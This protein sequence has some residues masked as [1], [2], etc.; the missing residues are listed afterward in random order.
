MFKNKI[1]SIQ[2]FKNEAKV[3][4]EPDSSP[5][6]WGHYKKFYSK[7]K[8]L[9]N[10]YDFSDLFFYNCYTDFGLKR[11]IYTDYE[12]FNYLNKPLRKGSRYNRLFVLEKDTKIKKINNTEYIVAAYRLGGDCDFNFN[13]KK[14]ALF[15]EII[16]SDSTAS[17]QE[18]ANASQQL[19]NCREMHH[20]LLNF[21]L[22][23]GIGNMQKFKGSNRYDR[24]DTFVY[25]LDKYFRGVSNS[26]L[27]YSSPNNKP[28]L[29][30]FLNDFKDIYEYC[31]TFY[32]ITEKTFI[33]E[34]IK[35]GSMPITNVTELMRYMNLAE[36]YWSIKEFAFF[37]KEFLAIG[38]YFLDGG[39]VFSKTELSTKIKNDFGYEQD[40]I[41]ELLIK[42]EKRGFITS[43]GNNS[44][45]R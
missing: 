15:L 32:F 30:S 34:I 20:N 16:E 4:F 3:Q 14:Y 41:D 1:D 35:Q 22:M 8:Y 45:T 24:L 31:A 13:E 25:E 21:S 29:I 38:D 26:I 37:Q 27:Q 33:N 28:A 5:A 11:G 12:W 43:I 42:C 40:E 19:A 10:N 2:T 44:Y 23:Q 9:N 39:T 18:K 6:A 17:K 7:N 36:K